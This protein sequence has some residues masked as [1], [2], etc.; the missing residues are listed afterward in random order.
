MERSATTAT[1]IAGTALAAY[2]LP[3]IAQICPPVRAALRIPNR[4]ATETGVLLSFDDGPHP[5]GT[6]A[7]LELLAKADATATFFLVGEQVE[8]RPRLAAE[9]AAAGHE[10]ALHC[11]R[12]RNLLRLTPRQLADD[13]SRAYAAIAEATGREPRLYRPPYGIFSAAAVVLTRRY[14]W[15][16]L[17]WSHDGRDWQQRA[18]PASIA[19]KATRH[20]TRGDVILLHDAD[21]YSASDSWRKTIAALPEILNTIDERG[22]HASAA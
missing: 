7:L 3:G 14:R 22:L 18:T 21:Y 2:W 16:P 6:V 5:Q 19:S 4:F 11:H 20:L 1:L 17:L 12:H 8:Q 13:L 9:I 15:Q 10:V